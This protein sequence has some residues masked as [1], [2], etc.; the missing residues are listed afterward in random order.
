M[1]ID[2]T[3]RA[4]EIAGDWEGLLLLSGFEDNFKLRSSLLHVGFV[5]SLNKHAI[6]VSILLD[7]TTNDAINLFGQ[8]DIDSPDASNSLNDLVVD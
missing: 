2:L 3:F 4:L 1:N 5:M 7:D 6:T 8:V